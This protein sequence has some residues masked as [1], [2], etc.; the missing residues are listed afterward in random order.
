MFVVSGKGHPNLSGIFRRDKHRVNECLLV[1]SI[2]TYLP[3]KLF[4]KK[5]CTIFMAC[6][7]LRVYYEDFIRP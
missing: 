3:L 7:L 1:N 2:T 4:S 5:T 6:S